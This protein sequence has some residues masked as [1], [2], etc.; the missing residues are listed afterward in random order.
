MSG[1]ER[2]SHAARDGTS[3]FTALFVRRP[4]LALVFNTLIVVAG[5]AAFFGMEVRELPDTDRPIITVRTTFEGASPQTVDQELTRVI[6]G[7]VARV[8]GLKSISSSSQFGSSRVTLEFSDDGIDAIARIAAELN[9]SIENIGARRLQTV[10][11]RVLDEVS[12]TATD[13]SGHRVVI[14]RAFVEAHI[15]ELARNTDLS[16][17][18]L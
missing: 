5:L 1:P 11:E 4:I 3:A 16:K 6:E 2:F 18:I 13:R 14:D 12:F 17:F 7:A 8:S 9:Q 10:M 15:G